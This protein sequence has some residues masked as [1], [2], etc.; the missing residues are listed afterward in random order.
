MTGFGEQRTRSFY[1]AELAGENQQLLAEA[2]VEPQ[3]GEELALVRLWMR[4]LLGRSELGPDGTGETSALLARL[5]ELTTRMARVQ[6]Q[7]GPAPG[8]SV[9]EMT[10]AVRRRLEAGETA[11]EILGEG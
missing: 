6:A 11:E 9:A 5:M 4:R 1:G 7:V 2:S 3:M 10:Y 8:N